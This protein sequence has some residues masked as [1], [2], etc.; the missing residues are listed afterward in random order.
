MDNPAIAIRPARFPDDLDTVVAIFQEYVRSP[1]ADLGFQDYEAEFAAL[2][3][4]YAA[5]DGQVLL[6]WRSG[7]TKVLPVFACQPAEKFQRSV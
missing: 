1:Q 2:P 6:A 5:P 3:G 7:P 4:K